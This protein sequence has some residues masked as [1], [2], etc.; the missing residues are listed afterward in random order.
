MF[1]ETAFPPGTPYIRENRALDKLMVR[2]RYIANRVKN[3]IPP[4][5]KIPSALR[6]LRLGIDLS[7]IEGPLDL[8]KHTYFVHE[9][10]PFMD[11]VKGVTDRLGNILDP[12]DVTHRIKD[13]RNANRINKVACHSYKAA[14]MSR[15]FRTDMTYE[16]FKTELHKLTMWLDKEYPIMADKYLDVLRHEAFS[17]YCTSSGNA[18]CSEASLKWDPLGNTEPFPH[19]FVTYVGSFEL[20]AKLEALIPDPFLRTQLLHFIPE[21]WGLA[22]RH[23]Y[24]T[25]GDYKYESEILKFVALV[26]Y[27]A[28]KHLVKC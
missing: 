8:R 16:M 11:V 25:V 2:I 4:Q 17:L 19:D 20:E 1:S 28:F 9:K 26:T 24:K 10:S 14:L 21:L 12:A 22:I 13:I 23:S 18:D 15:A 27:N 7:S 6:E 5:G 3:Q